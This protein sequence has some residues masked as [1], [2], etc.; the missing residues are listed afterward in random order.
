MSAAVELGLRSA[1]EPPEV[2]GAGRDDVRLLVATP[3]SVSHASF[4]QLPQFLAA[5]DLVVVN[6]SAHSRPRWPVTGGR[7]ASR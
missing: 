5:G 4:R 2:R 6:T 1:T 7:P 3:G